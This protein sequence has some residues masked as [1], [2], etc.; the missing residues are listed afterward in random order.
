LYQFSGDIRVEKKHRSLKKF[1]INLF[2]V[3]PDVFTKRELNGL[4]LHCINQGCP[5]HGT[6]EALEVSWGGKKER[7]R[8]TRKPF[9]RKLLTLIRVTYIAAT[10]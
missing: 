7:G 1:D 9:E 2:Q 5:W 3:F 8:K 4:C 10:E 6:Y